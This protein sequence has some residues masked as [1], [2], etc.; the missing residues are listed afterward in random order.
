MLN[1]FINK[2]E[3]AKKAIEHTKWCEENYAGEIAE[4]TRNT[5]IFTRPIVND[6]N[7]PLA[8]KYK[9]YRDC[10]ALMKDNRFKI[11]VVKADTVSAIFSVPG[12]PIVLNFA[13]YKHPGGMFIKGSSAQEESLCHESYLYNILRNFDDTY[14]TF[15]RD[16][17]NRALYQDRGLYTPNVRFIR[18]G[19]SK[20]A[21][22]ITCAAPNW[23]AASKYG[24]VSYEDNVYYLRSRINFI[25]EMA[26]Y[27]VYNS[28]DAYDKYLILGAF[29]CGV[30]K[31]DPHMVAR[32]YLDI[33]DRN[34][35]ISN[36]FKGIIFAIIDDKTVNTFMEEFSNY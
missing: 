17:L 6:I 5:K 36:A 32:I 22:I 27:Q 2:E 13:S 8:Y 29:G 31:Q 15:N 33:I 30:F 28:D 16:N 26:A 25:M 20:F 11:M 1:Y 14:Y 4:C 7:G 23:G 3:R 35:V 12:V 24:K 9:Q 18:D 10:T 34:F 19:K 21:D